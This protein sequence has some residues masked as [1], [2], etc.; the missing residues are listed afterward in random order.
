[1]EVYMEVSLCLFLLRVEAYIHFSYILFIQ[2][3]QKHGFL[4]AHWKTLIPLQRNRA[5]VMS[6]SA[7]LTQFQPVPLIWGSNIVSL[8]KF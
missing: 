5:A 6:H 4:T 2:T 1:M 3:I 7:K 8:V